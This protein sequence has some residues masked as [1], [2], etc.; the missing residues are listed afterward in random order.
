LVENN[1]DSGV[2]A[3]AVVYNDDPPEENNGQV[4]ALIVYKNELYA[5]GYFKYSGSKK[6]VNL[7]KWD[8]TEWSSLGHEFGVIFAMCV[9]KDEL[10][11]SGNFKKIGSVDARNIAKWDGSKW[12]AVGDGLDSSP[13]GF[14]IY[15]DELVV[16]G[17]TE[18]SSIKVKGIAKWDGSK[19]S[20]LDGGVPND[21]MAMAEYK[22]ELYT[23]GTYIDVNTTEP[24]LYKW[25]GKKWKGLASFDGAVTGLVGTEQGL[26]I[27]GFFSEVNKKELSRFGISTD[28]KKWTKV[29]AQGSYQTR[30][31]DAVGSLFYYNSA[32][33]ATGKI[34]DEDEMG[35]KT[36]TYPTQKTGGK[37]VGDKWK[38][39]GS[40]LFG[41]ISTFAVFRGE[42]Y[43]A[44][45]FIISGSV[46]FS[47]IAKA[48]LK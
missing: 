29:G 12:S 15:K 17:I 11:I 42:L 13:S 28:G 40:E 33:Y 10:Y 25:D 31:K 45:S 27:T 21:I 43:A 6:I 2:H 35:N 26:Y 14:I 9:Y 1:K 39:F 4:N 46:N 48:K 24:N 19:W 44:G 8:G 16:S 38:A 18:A 36:G 23:G 22:D 32:L 34:W 37:L 3:P 7:A 30:S 47:N 41:G 5:G 20:A